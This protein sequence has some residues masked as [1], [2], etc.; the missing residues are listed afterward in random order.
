MTDKNSD[1]LTLMML[2]AAGGSVGAMRFALA[3]GGS[4]RGVLCF[5]NCNE[6]KEFCR[7]RGGD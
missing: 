2:A 7:S 1:G 3:N 5:C 4:M 6:T